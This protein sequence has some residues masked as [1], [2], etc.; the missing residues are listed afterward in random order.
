MACLIVE[1]MMAFSGLYA[2]VAAKFK[3]T[4]RFHLVGWRARIVGL[5]W[6]APFPVSFFIA[7]VIGL[8]VNLGVFPES[9]MTYAGCIEPVVMIGAVVGSLAF[10]YATD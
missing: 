10:A 7:L 4:S 3:L 9:A 2:L 6:I 1:I 8:L 5:F